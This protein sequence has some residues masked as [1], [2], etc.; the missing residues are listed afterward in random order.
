MPPE[1]RPGGGALN[2]DRFRRLSVVMIARNESSQPHYEQM[3]ETMDANTTWTRGVRALL[4]S[5]LTVGLTACAASKPQAPPSMEPMK[6]QSGAPNKKLKKDHFKSDQTGNLTERELRRILDAPVFVEEGTRIGVVPVATDYKVDDDLPLATV[7]KKLSQ[8]LEDTGFFEVATEVSTE[9]PK[10]R[11]VAG[12]R[13]LAARYRS[14]YLMLYRHRF[15]DRGR[16]N[17]WGWTYPT[18][19]GLFA[20]PGKT[21]EVAGVM[22][23]TLFDV[24]TG[25]IL[26]TV[27]ERV[28]D[29]RT[30]NIW[31]NDH[32]RRAMKRKL[33]KKATEGLSE[34]VTG[35]VRRLV[36]AEPDEAS[37][38]SGRSA[39]NADGPDGRVVLSE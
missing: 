39:S 20:S 15:V 30:M 32:K 4:A 36:A 23:A 8:S 13:E 7:P 14:Q 21:V 22:E 29:E 28:R 17:G 12:L 10:D 33:M 31:H 2:L 3:D 34:K 24:R 38:R 5:L 26:F 16:V 6:V 1:A 11:G 37:E 25:T 19:V 27:Y 9:W 18:V 35:K